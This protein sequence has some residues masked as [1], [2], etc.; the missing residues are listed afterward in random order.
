M[1]LDST[2]TDQE[3]RAAIEDNASYLAE[4]SIMKARSYYTAKKILLN[5]LAQ[6]VDSGE[7]GD[8]VTLDLRQHRQDAEEALAYINAFGGL[9]GPDGKTAPR[10]VHRSFRHFR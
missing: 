3:V 10:V 4:G 1:A 8:S 5:R 2:S 7:S 9:L 6:R